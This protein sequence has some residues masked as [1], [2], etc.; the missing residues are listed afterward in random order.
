MGGE[1]GCSSHWRGRRLTSRH[2]PHLAV[3]LGS[4]RK[5]DTRGRSV[6][7]C[8]PCCCRSTSCWSIVVVGFDGSHRYVETAAITV[9]ALP[10][11]AYL[12]RSSR[13]G[14]E[15]ACRSSGPPVGRSIGRR[16][17]RPPTVVSG[18][19]CPR[20]GQR[21][22]ACPAVGRCRCDRWGGPLRLVQYA[23]LGGIVGMPAQLIAVHSYVEAAL[24]PARAA[25]AGDTGFG[26]SL[27]RSR[28]SFAAWTKVS[29]LAS[30][31]Q[32]SPSRARCW[33]PCLDEPGSL[34]RWRSV[35]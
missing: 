7:S 19:G 29:A 10:L 14:L 15:P 18:G 13:P 35:G 25:I 20:A 31:V 28:P 33:V 22:W 9:V 6:R 26:D 1:G 16:R 30:R 27:P 4:L 24:R 32:F 11:L 12:H 2:G 17:W 34:P 5:L 21:D 8:S 3:G 23:I